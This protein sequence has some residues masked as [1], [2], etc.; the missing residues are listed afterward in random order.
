[1]SALLLSM[2][3]L[4]SLNLSGYIDGRTE[5]TELEHDPVARVFCIGLYAIGC[6]ALYFLVTGMPR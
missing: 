3:A 2:L 5:Q 4:L 1:M 6:G